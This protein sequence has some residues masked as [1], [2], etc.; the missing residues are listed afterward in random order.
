MFPQL[1]LNNPDDAVRRGITSASEALLLPVEFSRKVG[2][3]DVDYEIGYQFVH[4]GPN[5]WLT[6]LVVGHE[7][8]PKFEMDTEFYSQGTFHPSANEPTLGLGGRYKI[9]NPIIALFMAGRSLES[10]RSNQSY[11]VGYFGV[12]FLLSLRS[13]KSD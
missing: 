11:F 7:F 9:R 12:Q 13:H 10:A 2:P 1:F 3:V 8:T 5:G 4:K 6:G